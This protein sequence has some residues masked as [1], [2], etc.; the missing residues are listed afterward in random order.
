MDKISVAEEVKMQSKNSISI[1]KGLL[2]NLDIALDN[3]LSLAKERT[4]TRKEVRKESTELSLHEDEI[5][6]GKKVLSKN[7]ETN[8]VYMQI[9]LHIRKVCEF[10]N[11]YRVFPLMIYKPINKKMFR[12]INY[13]E[14]NIDHIVDTGHFTW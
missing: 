7:Y 10:C 4:K 5:V 1:N 3:S 6:D 12:Q 9:L 2:S 11:E 13:T 14:D 8:Q